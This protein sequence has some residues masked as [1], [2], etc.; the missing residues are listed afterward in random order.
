MMSE[1]PTEDQ[2]DEA[3]YELG[4]VLDRMLLGLYLADF[5]LL[6]RQ[7]RLEAITAAGY[8]HQLQLSLDSRHRPLPTP[9]P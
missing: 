1:V 5:N 2:V 6:K 4:L 3:A 9:S 7:G 8:A